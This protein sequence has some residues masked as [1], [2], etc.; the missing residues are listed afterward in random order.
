[1]HQICF[2]MYVHYKYVSGKLCNMHSF[3]Y[4]FMFNPFA[5]TKSRSCQPIKTG[6]HCKEV[7]STLCDVGAH[8]VNGVFCLRD[9]LCERYS[10]IPCSD[11]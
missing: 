9:R 11:L 3:F 1:M 4:D 10:E 7:T 8:E 6:K 5:D 2:L